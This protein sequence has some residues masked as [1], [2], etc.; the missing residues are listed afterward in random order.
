MKLR[1]RAI[2]I[3]LF[4]VIQSLVTVVSHKSDFKYPKYGNALTGGVSE[5]IK[6]FHVGRTKTINILHAAETDERRNDDIINEILY[7]IPPTLTF[8]CENFRHYDKIN[9]IRINNIFIVD[10][11][12][13]F[14][15]L[16]A[17]MDTVHFD[18][19]GHYLIVITTYVYEQ[20]HIMSRMFDDLWSNLIVNSAILWHVPANED[21]AIL[22]TYYPFNEFYCGGTMPIEQNH[23]KDG[24][25][26]HNTSNFFPN[27]VSNLYRCP[28]TVAVIPT[29]PF[30]MVS[31]LEEDGG[32]GEVRVEGIDGILLNMLA[33]MMNFRVKVDTFESQGVI[34]VENGTATGAQAAKSMKLK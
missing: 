6:R 1:K 23:F 4:V 12:A 33:Q 18:Y 17:L 21:E 30:M 24:K 11:Y 31:Q 28:L 20:Y 9:R 13:S 22:F 10:N 19:Q 27:K 7:H 32:G 29:P 26:F 2:Q 15:N 14:R 25:W 3:L 34:N 5:I 16:L 8:R